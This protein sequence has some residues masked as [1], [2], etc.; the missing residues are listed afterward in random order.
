MLQAV[1][2]SLAGAVKFRILP[3]P[4]SM[5]NFT[6]SL[7]TPPK[8]FVN[9]SEKNKTAA[10][11]DQITVF[12]SNLFIFFFALGIEKTK[13]I[14]KIKNGPKGISLLIVI[15]EKPKSKAIPARAPIQKLRSKA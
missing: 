6:S 2:P 8:K 10:T 7:G 5:V 15:P 14:P 11:P 4:K 13:K 9:K 1:L 12:E 3:S